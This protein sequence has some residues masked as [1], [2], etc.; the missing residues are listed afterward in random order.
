M[1]RNAPAMQEMQV[2]SLGGKIPWRSAWQPSLVFLPGKSHE[3][4]RLVGYGPW[5]HRLRH[6]KQLS[7]QHAYI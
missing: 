1:L 4:R 5:G 2:Q 3:Q 6:D 7:M